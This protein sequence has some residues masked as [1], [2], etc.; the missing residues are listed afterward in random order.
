[1]SGRRPPSES[2]MQV[3]EMVG[4]I[5][6][7]RLALGDGVTPA[8]PLVVW[9]YRAEPDWAAATLLSAIETYRG[10]L[11][12]VLEKPGRNWVRWPEEAKRVFERGNWRTDSEFLSF[13]R[14]GKP[15]FCSRALGDLVTLLEHVELE[16]GRIATV[17]KG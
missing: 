16:L 1:M 2:V 11:R 4:E 5:E 17:D 7:A 14:V 10:Q 9:R 8:A 15:A 12:W 13:L 6:W 3:L